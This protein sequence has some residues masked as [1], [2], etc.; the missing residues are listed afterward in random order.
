MVHHPQCV[1]GETR[2]QFTRDST[3]FAFESLVVEDLDVD[4]LAGIPFMEINDVSVRPS[5]REITTGD[6]LVHSYGSSPSNAQTK[7][8]DH[9]H[10]LRATATDTVWPG[11][12]IELGIPDDVS[13]QASWLAVEPHM[14]QKDRKGPQALVE[15]TLVHSV[16]HKIRI[17]NL[18]SDPILVKKNN[19]F[20]QI[21]TIY[22]CT[23]RTQQPTLRR[24]IRIH[25]N[26]S[27]P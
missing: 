20:C 21:R 18:T 26:P 16:G 5:K 2:L 8:R 24:S 6:K 12:F 4:I 1:V 9:A 27:H 13:A 25:R 23:A 10:V 15:P 7:S 19:H 17:P 3:T 11:Q 14:S 22:I